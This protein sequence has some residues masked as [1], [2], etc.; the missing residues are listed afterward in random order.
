MHYSLILHYTNQ[1]LLYI[2]GF[3][4]STTIHQRNLKKHVLKRHEDM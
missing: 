2:V 4:T 1:Y 3:A